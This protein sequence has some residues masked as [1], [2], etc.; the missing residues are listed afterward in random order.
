MI[1][2]VVAAAAVMIAFAAPLAMASDYS[3]VR[4]FAKRWAV[5]S[6]AVAG[7]AAAGVL[8]GEVALSALCASVWICH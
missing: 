7:F 1:T 6:L 5:Y 2:D 8:L 4:G 3:G